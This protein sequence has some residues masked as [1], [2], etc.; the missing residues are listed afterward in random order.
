MPTCPTCGK[1]FSGM[2]F[3]ATPAT[4]CRDCRKTKADSQPAR[5]TA[6]AATAEAPASLT[7]VRKGAPVA[8]YALVGFNV[9]VYLAMG[10]SGASWT[11]PT[12]TDALHWGA[13][14]GPLTL[15]GQWWRL[16]S[17]TFVHFGIVH[18]GFNMWC[19]WELGRALEFLMGRKAFILTYVLSGLAASLV[20]IAWDPWRVSAGASG[21]IFG[22]AG[23]FV[24]YLYFRKTP[25]DPAVVRQKLKSLAIFIAYN[26]F[27]GLRSGI[28][29]SAHLGG[30]AAGLVLGAILPPMVFATKSPAATLPVGDSDSQESKRTKVAITVALCS[31]AVLTLGAM[32]I[33]AVNAPAALY[34]KAVVLDRRGHWESAINVMQQA[35]ELDPKLLYGQALLGEWE[36]EHNDPSGAVGPLEQ[37]LA[38]DDNDVDIANNLSLAYLGA[39][40][41]QDSIGEMQRAF[42]ENK[43]DYGTGCFVIGVALDRLGEFRSAAQWLES[44]SRSDSKFYA[45]RDALAHVEI[46]EGNIDQA[47]ELYGEALTTYPGDQVAQHNVAL[48]KSRTTGTATADL[49]PVVMP[50]SEL[51]AKSAAWP[52]YP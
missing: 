35:V 33:H 25:V 27:Y 9:V 24:S 43:Q 18:I 37:A 34:G 42:A 38:L 47:R 48:L 52:Y 32:R 46:E 31:A 2:S 11:S 20:S 14:F 51:L 6:I 1:P 19:L 40:R 12:I 50:Y 41:L 29:N 16:F 23:A 3:G 17:S 4:Q 45:A 10:I 26:L 28:D 5:Q 39:G 15:S 8:T 13:D 36:L 22:V 21:A 49:A 44:A 7:G 30:V